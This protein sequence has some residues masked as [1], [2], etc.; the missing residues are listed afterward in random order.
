VPWYAKAAAGAAAAYTLS[1]ISLIPDSVGLLGDLSD[2]IVVPLGIVFAVRLIPDDLM[3][4]F[5]TE[6]MRRDVGPRAT[7]AQRS[8]R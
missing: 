8:L 7:Y 1:P 3:K 4:E 2:V 5:R 6:A